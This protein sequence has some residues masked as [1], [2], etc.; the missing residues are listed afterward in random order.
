LNRYFVPVYV[1]NEDYGPNGAAL[2]AEK[3]EYTRIYHETLDA[4]LS[5]GTVHVYLLK[6]DGHV[7]D[8]MHVA[9]A[10]ETNRLAPMLERAIQ[11]LETPVGRPLV[12][13][14]A[15]SAPPNS[16][17]GSLVLHLTARALTTGSWHEFPAENWIVLDRTQ[18]T[19]LLPPG[20]ATVG[21]SWTIG[22]ELAA[23]LLTYFYPQ[24]ENNDLSTNEIE[25]QSLQARVLSAHGGLVRARIDG[26]LVMKHAFYPHRPDDK[27]VQARVVGFVDF[28]P[29]T[30]KIR[31][32]R[33]VTDGA[34]Y[35]VV[36]FAV[37]LHSVE[38]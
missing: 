8:S 14:G 25:Q 37:E 15:Q 4:H 11:T 34:T 29:A 22:R 19:K 28:E 35:G 9:Q 33:L 36:P 23:R 16:A 24:T 13:P 27:T 12:P 3:A 20:A 18:W 31:T 2:P 7:L 38:G 10:S 6:P 17:P 30:H 5:A 21:A 1:S 26:R 32:L